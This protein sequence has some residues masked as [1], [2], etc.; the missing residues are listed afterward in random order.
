MSSAKMG[1]IALQLRHTLQGYGDGQQLTTKRC[2]YTII[3]GAIHDPEDSPVFA[4]AT[5]PRQI[6]GQWDTLC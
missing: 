3:A 1:E 5:S 6:H 4:T 2:Q